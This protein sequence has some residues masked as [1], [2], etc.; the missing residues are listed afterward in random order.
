MKDFVNAYILNAHDRLLSSK[1][2]GFW[3]WTFTEMYHG[4]CEELWFDR[5]SS[6]PNQ[7]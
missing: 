3:L 5:R 2:E 6:K 1:V 4:V 7:V